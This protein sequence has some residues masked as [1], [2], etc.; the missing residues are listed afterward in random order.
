MSGIRLGVDLG[1]TKTEI[2]ALDEAG[3]ECLRR[4]VDSPREEYAATLETIAGLV[5]W[6]EEQLGA[7]ATVGIGTPGALSRATGTIKNANSTWLNG[8]PLHRDLEARLERPVRLANDANCFAL[9]EAADGA[10]TGAELVFGVIVGTGT[11][12][13][14]VVDREVRTGANAIAGEWGHN[15]LPWPAAEEVPGPACYCGLNGCIETF[16]SGPGLMADHERCT[17]ASRDPED[18]V[19][20]AERGE[21]ACEAT[22]RRYEHRMARSLAHVINVLDPDTIV[23]GGGMGNIA[24]LY[25]TVPELWGRFVFS[26]RV[27]TR[28]VPPRYGDSSG[29]RGAAW[30]WGPEEAAALAGGVS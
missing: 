18:I 14:V 29:V 20:G 17:G 3:R 22:L 10:A 1:G 5:A 8:R 27:D 30:L 7:P 26:D 23:L 15:P 12:A 16:L 11:G 6:A 25:R 28:L 2:I 13:G 4:R 9:S 24:R 19:A 21:R